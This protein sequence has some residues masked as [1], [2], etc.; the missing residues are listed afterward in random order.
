[1][2]CRYW[3]FHSELGRIYVEAA[4]VTP[5]PKPRKQANARQ[6]KSALAMPNHG[7]PGFA[8]SPGGAAGAAGAAGGGPAA[9]PGGV[10]TWRCHR[11]REEALTLTQTLTLQP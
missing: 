2:P 10:T 9:R 7:S 1:V 8:G 11:S 6:R 5:T 4:A 3:R